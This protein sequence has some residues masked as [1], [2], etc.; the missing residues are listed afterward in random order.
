MKK[1]M[2]ELILRNKVDSK[3]PRTSSSSRIGDKGTFDQWETRIS[4]HSMRNNDAVM[5]CSKAGIPHADCEHEQA[6]CCNAE[7]N[8]SALWTEILATSRN[9]RSTAR[10]RRLRKSRSKSSQTETRTFPCRGQNYR[11]VTFEDIMITSAEAWT[12]DFRCALQCKQDEIASKLICRVMY[13]GDVIP[14]WANQRGECHVA[15]GGQVL[16]WFQIEKRVEMSSGSR[17]YRMWFD[18]SE[19]SDISLP[20]HLTSVT[21]WLCFIYRHLLWL[22]HEEFNISKKARASAGC[23]GTEQSRETQ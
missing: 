8:T 2:L 11:A 12:S 23:R 13:G 7:C 10:R 15:W 16:S 18:A 1:S 9:R 20:S 6:P 14:G 22:S 4:H 21:F 17:V 19:K 5:S 3:N